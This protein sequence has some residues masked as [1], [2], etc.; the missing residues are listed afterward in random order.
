MQL[1]PVYAA[2]YVV[3]ISECALLHCNIVGT[4]EPLGEKH[5]GKTSMAKRKGISA[6]L[7]RQVFARDGFRCRYCGVQAGEPNVVLHADHLVS[8]ADGGT[9]ALDNLITAC[10]RCNGGKSARSL[11]TAPGSEAAIEYAAKA[12]STLK[13]Q[14]DAIA[15]QIEARQQFRDAVFDVIQDIWRGY[16]IVIRDRDFDWICRLVDTHGIEKVAGWLSY[17]RGRGITPWNASRYVGGMLRGMK[18]QGTL[19]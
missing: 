2:S 1:P 8:V 5:Q 7:R 15:R 4:L 3:T 6:S 18:Q 11:D 12:A 19:A 13:E 16:S 9:N 10:Q 17:A 14:A